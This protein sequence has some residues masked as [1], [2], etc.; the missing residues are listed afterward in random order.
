MICGLKIL[1][2]KHQ[3]PE[4]QIE[5][6]MMSSDLQNF[7]IGISILRSQTFPKSGQSSG[8][9]AGAPHYNIIALY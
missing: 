7:K 9:Y 4:V 5:K 2:L 1:S 8:K 3:I 6:I